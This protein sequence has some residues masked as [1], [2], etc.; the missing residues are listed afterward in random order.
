MKTIEVTVAGRKYLITPLSIRKN[1]KWRK[2]FDSPIKDAA[3]L[4][5][6]IGSFVDVEYEDTRQMIGRVG[7]AVSGSLS[8]IVEHLLASSDTITEA[9]FD[10]SPAMKEDQDYIEEN[11]YD[12][13]IVDAFLEILGLAFPFGQAIRGLMSLGQAE[14]QTEPN[15]PSQSSGSSTKKLKRKT[16]RS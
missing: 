14:P 11:G 6:E 10:Y 15:S 5:A 3:N 16:S 4:L 2:Q 1:R 12:T 8:P 9:V 13:E 7:Q